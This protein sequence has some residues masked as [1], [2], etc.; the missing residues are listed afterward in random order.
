MNLITLLIKE[1]PHLMSVLTNARINAWLIIIA[2]IA[3]F[4]ALIAISARIRIA[5]LG[6]PIPFTM[7]S[8]TVLL[9]GM[10]LGPVQGAASVA[11]YLAAIASGQPWD[12]NMRGSLALVGDTAGYL[13][14]FIPTAF[15]AGLAWK[16]TGWKQFGLSLLAGTV[17]SIVLL[18]TGAWGFSMFYN[19]P[20]SAALLGAVVPFVVS[21]A[22]KVLLASSVVMLGE[23]SWLRWFKRDAG[24]M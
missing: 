15:I 20:Y 8:F 24:M 13:I 19:T 9:A 11:A 21:S 17:A 10:V 16:Q 4:A 22:G 7:Q 23:Q 2:K 6:T 5:I 14:G 18:M 12:T 3:L 1:I